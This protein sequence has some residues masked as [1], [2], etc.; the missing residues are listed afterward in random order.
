MKLDRRIIHEQI[1]QNVSG[2]VMCIEDGKIIYLNPMAS[3]ILAKPEEDLENRFFAEIFFGQNEQFDQTILD[4]IYDPQNSIEKIV[5]YFDGL[6]TRYLYLKISP[7]QSSG[8]AI[9]IL[10]DDITELMNLHVVTLDLKKI[11]ARLEEQNRIS[12][13]SRDRFSR[14][15]EIDELTGLYNKSRIETLCNK[16]FSDFDSQWIAAYF[17][18]DLDNFKEANETYGQEF[19]DRIL[20]EFAD[21]LRSNFRSTDY[22]GRFGS[23]EFVVLMRDIPSEDIIRLK[24]HEILRSARD[25]SID[26][27]YPDITASIGITIVTEQKD[28]AEIFKAADD[29][30][31]LVKSRGRNGF[32]IDCGDKVS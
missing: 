10:I 22:I 26:G 19:G 2:G 3:Q 16:Y 21:S 5:E 25:L 11:N 32:S 8:M 24:A 14:E 12:T 4:A 9:T 31:Y 18:I 29:S 6:V 27:K 17:V 28:Y 23:D 7:I 1:L 20:Q 15:S 13:L 30:V